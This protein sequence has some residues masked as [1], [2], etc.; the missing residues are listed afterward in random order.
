MHHRPSTPAPSPLTT[1][2]FYQV[3]VG[4]STSSSSTSSLLQS[5]LPVQEH[6]LP[7]CLCFFLDENYVFT[8]D[9]PSNKCIV[10]IVVD[11][12]STATGKSK[13]EEKIESSEA[14]EFSSEQH[15]NKIKNKSNSNNKSITITGEEESLLFVLYE[16]SASPK[17]TKKMKKNESICLADVDW[18]DVILAY[19]DCSSNK[20]NIG[21]CFARTII[22]HS[23]ESIIATSTATTNFFI[24]PSGLYQL[25]FEGRNNGNLILRRRKNKTST[26][27]NSDMVWK[28]IGFPSSSCHSSDDKNYNKT[29]TTNNRNIKLSMQGD[30]SLVLRDTIGQKTSWKALT[31]GN[32]GAYCA[33]DDGGQISVIDIKTGS[34]LY[35]D[36]IP[37]R[38][39]C[40]LRC[41]YGGNR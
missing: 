25:S 19:P 5:Q 18:I 26:W 38:F 2:G 14:L 21:G 33:L 10:Q 3:L 20:Y 7:L 12:G 23:N 32:P 41:L 4:F 9:H 29:T 16:S 30:G 31:Q 17:N 13:I 35:I 6:H 40:K 39:K 1:A 34:P 27:R 24:S 36:G 11:G 22:L 37:R 15:Q 8:F 28:K